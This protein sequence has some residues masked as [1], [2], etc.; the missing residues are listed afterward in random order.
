MAERDRPDPE[1]PQLARECE[2][3]AG[4]E[5]VAVAGAGREE[6][7][8]PVAPQQRCL[9]PGEQDRVVGAQRRARRVPERPVAQ[10]PE[11]AAPTLDRAEEAR[12]PQPDVDGAEAAR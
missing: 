5:P 12:M 1:C 7:R 4:A 10:R 11:V 9:E 8:G 3:R 2:G 6:E